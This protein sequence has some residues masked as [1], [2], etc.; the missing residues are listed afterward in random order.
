MI[1]LLWLGCGFFAVFLGIIGLLLPVMPTVPFLLVAT[2]AF[3]RSS[4]AL[5]EKILRHPTIGPTILAWQQRGAIGRSSK[6]YAIL[7]MSGGVALALW[8]SIPVWLVLCQ[9]TVCTAVGIY[10]LTRPSA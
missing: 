1:R 8:A 10:I 7:A 9:A 5:N 4:P 2:W 6:I 3:A